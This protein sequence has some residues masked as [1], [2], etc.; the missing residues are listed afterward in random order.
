MNS[1][2]RY[3]NAP[4][5][6]APLIVFRICFGFLMAYSHLRFQILGW[7]ADHFSGS[8]F[9]FKYYGF[10]WVQVAPLPVMYALNFLLV[11]VAFC[12]A[13][14]YQYR[15]AVAI[16]FVVF[17]YFQLCD[18]TYYLNHYYF[19]LLVNLILF[20]V[21]ANVSFSSHLNFKNFFIPKNYK[22][23]C[24]ENKNNLEK[25]PKDHKKI[26]KHYDTEKKVFFI[27]ISQKKI[28][29]W[30]YLLIKFMICVVYFYAGIAK[31]NYDWLI[32]ALPLRIWLPAH[33]H[34]PLIGFLFG[35]TITAYVFSWFGMLYDTNI[36]FFLW[37]QKTAPY[38][39]IFVV[40]FHLGTALLFQIGIFPLIM[41]VLTTY[42]F[43][44]TVHEKILAYL[45][46]SI[47]RLSP[48]TIVYIPE[49]FENKKYSL[50]FFSAS[51]LGLFV[52][53]QLLFPFRYLLYKGNLF[54][55]EEGY[56]F[57][58]RVML[59]EKSGSATFYVQDPQTGREGIVENSFFLKPHQEKQMSFQPDMIVQFGRFLSHYYSKP[60]YPPPRVRVEAYVTLNGRKSRLLIQPDIDIS[61]LRDG[62]GAK[63]WIIHYPDL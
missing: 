42:F 32:E 62:W 35:W 47:S 58:W 38:A 61:K 21:P 8:K 23:S 20:F 22:K 52:V 25:R 48:E 43:P 11:V 9:Y 53:F 45:E 15:L 12:I 55:T 46:S 60:G 26:H 24:F 2:L 50:N 54:W 27:S 17:S 14:G 33:Q 44:T 6:A 49:E 7:V 34:L 31:I 13:L 19:I 63:K 40:V 18:L 56:R 36:P 29:T 3:L 30:A 51:V 16:H 10:E 4:V 41:I 59:V 5:S 37:N 57:S 39:Y 1:I 28:P